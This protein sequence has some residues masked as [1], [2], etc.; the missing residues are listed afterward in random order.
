MKYFKLPL[1][2]LLLLT[3][4]VFAEDKKTYD[5]QVLIYAHITPDTL[6]AEAWPFLT[7]D[8]LKSFHDQTTQHLPKMLSG[9]ANHLQH[10]KKILEKEADY[11]I[12]VDRSYRESF[13]ADNQSFSF[14]IKGQNNQTT[15]HGLMTITLS[16]YFD[17]NMNLLLS[18]PTTLLQKI[19]PTHYFA[20]L[21]T[22]SFTFKFFQ[23]R[24]M[25]SDELNFLEHPL[26]GVLIKIVKV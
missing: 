15:I 12:L 5:I 9:P 21:K 17:V 11:Q 25:K 8:D 22:P 13:I 26:M 7:A 19:D 10:E 4:S 3:T 1:F 16:H 6:Q 20:N 2:F 24:R 18:E 14:P 23:N